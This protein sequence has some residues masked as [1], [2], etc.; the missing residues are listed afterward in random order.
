MGGHVLSYVSPYL[1]GVRE[2]DGGSGTKDLLDDK[3]ILRYDV[4]LAWE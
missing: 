4:R 2:I 1:C 3:E